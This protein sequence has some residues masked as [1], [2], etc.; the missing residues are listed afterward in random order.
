MVVY[1]RQHFSGNVV[2]AQ[3]RSFVAVIDHNVTECETELPA[4]CAVCRPLVD[5]WLRQLHPAQVWHPGCGRLAGKGIEEQVCFAGLSSDPKPVF[6]VLRRVLGV[7][8]VE[9]A[10]FGYRRRLVCRERTQKL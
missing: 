7:L 3:L 2:S 5:V 6:A 9:A 8:D 10:M 4:V 1:L